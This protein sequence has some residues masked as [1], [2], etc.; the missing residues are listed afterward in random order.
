MSDNLAINEDFAWEKFISTGKVDDYIKYYK[1]KNSDFDN[2]VTP[3]GGGSV[4]ENECQRNRGK[5]N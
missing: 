5:G 4:C 1:S 3:D 2:V